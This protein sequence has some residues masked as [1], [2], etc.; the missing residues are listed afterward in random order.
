MQDDDFYLTPVVS[1]RTG[2]IIYT[3]SDHRLL[4]FW[5]FGSYYCVGDATITATQ[6]ANSKYLSAEIS[7]NF[8][9]T[10]GDSDGVEL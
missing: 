7:A 5:D 9:I 6:N 3:S 4:C 2:D 1:N 8:T 10:I